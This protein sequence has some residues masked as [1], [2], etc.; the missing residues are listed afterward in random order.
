MGCPVP[1]DEWLD[2]LDGIPGALR[3]C[4]GT[5]VPW[6]SKA[7]SPSA[8]IG[9]IAP[10]DHRIGSRSRTRTHRLRPGSKISNT[11]GGIS[12][13]RGRLCHSLRRQHRLGL[14]VIKVTDGQVFGHDF[15]G[16][17]FTGTA[18]ED[19]Y[20]SIDFDVTMEVKP[21]VW[22]MQGT[23]P[24]ELPHSRR[25]KHKFPLD[26]GEGKPQYI[27]LPPGMVTLMVKGGVDQF[28]DAATHGFEFRLRK[29][30]RHENQ[31]PTRP[32]R[33]TLGNM[34]ELAA[35]LGGSST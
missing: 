6:A 20:G 17:K 31:A 11:Q 5:H 33:M 14:A 35:A 12:V 2:S 34:R 1:R 4:S 16:S 10:G 29:N 19:D 3:R 9:R 18:V 24:Q 13:Y 7:S 21:G 26:F 22:L 27:F 25:L 8:A 15:V 28:S 32:A 23:G 30:Q